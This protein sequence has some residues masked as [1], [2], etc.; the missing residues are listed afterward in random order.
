MSSQPRTCCFCMGK[1]YQRRRERANGRSFAML[2]GYLY[3]CRHVLMKL[4]SLP[5]RH[6][7]RIN[8]SFCLV[9]TN[10][11]SPDS[12]DF[13]ARK[14]Q[15][16]VTRP[17]FLLQYKRK[18]VIWLRETTHIPEGAQIYTGQCSRMNE[19]NA[20]SCLKHRCQSC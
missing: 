15:C 3:S 17:F 6:A 11:Q 4:L 19:I 8:T 12:G 13:V 1:G 20:W 2:A 5:L 18:I 10:Q 14:F 16:K 9:T 7:Q